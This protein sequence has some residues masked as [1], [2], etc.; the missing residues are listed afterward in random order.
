MFVDS[1]VILDRQ[2]IPINVQKSLC[3]IVREVFRVRIVVRKRIIGIRDLN[4]RKIFSRKRR[5]RLRPIKG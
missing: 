1:A 4:A 3:N 5:Y 2:F